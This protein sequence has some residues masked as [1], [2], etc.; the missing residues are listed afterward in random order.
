M[1]SGKN[2]T[3]ERHIETVFKQHYGK[4]CNLAFSY[5]KNRDSAEEVVQQFFVELIYHKR[6]KNIKTSLESYLYTGVT[7]AT[8]KYLKS[9]SQIQAVPIELLQEQLT[10]VDPVSQDKEY[11]KIVAASIEILPPKCKEAFVLIHVRNLSY[12]EA[13]EVL[14]VSINTIKTQIKR[15]F[16]LIRTEIPSPF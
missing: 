1:H 6:Y 11:A 3:W 14:D 4:L 12:Q 2:T 7:Y 8:F 13:A 16:K 15:A 9:S 5:L 10:Q